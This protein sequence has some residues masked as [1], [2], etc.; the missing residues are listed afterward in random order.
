MKKQYIFIFGIVFLAF[1]SCNKQ[2]SLQEYYVDKQ[3][4]NAFISLDLPASLVSLNDDSANETKEAMASIKKL[5]ILAFKLNDANKEEFTVELVKV[6][7]ILKDKKYNELMRI[8]HEG[9]NIVIKYLGSDEAIDEFIVFAS[10]KNKGFALARILG[11]KMN[12][13]KIMHLFK[14]IKDIDKN[15]SAFAQIEGIIGE[16]E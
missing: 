5:N 2:P 10:D 4:S 3:N 8:N 12:P 6:K 13:D 1:T 11:N 16:L 15:N 9:A 7:E 14:N